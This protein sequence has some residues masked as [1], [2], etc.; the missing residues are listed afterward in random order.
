MPPPPSLDNI[1]IS[2]PVELT[3]VNAQ[4][5]SP[6]PQ[7]APRKTKHCI[8]RLLNLMYSD[9]YLEDTIASEGRCTRTQLDAG[10]VGSNS[11]Y[12]S[13]I[14]RS[15]VDGANETGGI[16][17]DDPQ[18]HL[19]AEG[20][21]P[22]IRPQQHSQ[23]KLYDMHNNV[24]SAYQK[25][26]TNFRKSGTHDS[27][28]FNF[29]DPQKLHLESSAGVLWSDIYYLY[30]IHRKRGEPV[31][32]FLE[33]DLGDIGF[34]GVPSLVRESSPNSPRSG[35]KSSRPMSRRKRPRYS[36]TSCDTEPNLPDVKKK[37]LE[38]KVALL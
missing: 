13:N 37:Y 25:A 17:V 6:A 11:A 24:R 12:W 3:S 15:F 9:Q 19:Q 29:C 14:H 32:V 30:C 35:S 7:L 34:G 4:S 23:R 10:E 2:L 5:T 36:D 20:I 33:T 16:A 28:F 38:E 26:R 31:G 21:S 27:D 8:P 18:G 22:D 1:G